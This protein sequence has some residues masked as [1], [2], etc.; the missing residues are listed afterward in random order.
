MKKIIMALAVVAI[1]TVGQAAAFAWST[2]GT[3]HPA[4]DSSA[5]LSFTAYLINS[6]TITQGDLL[7]ALRNGGSITDYSAL[8]TFTGSGKVT[9]TKFNFDIDT[10]K[11]LSAYFVIVDGD[12]VFLSKT[13]TKAAQATSDATLAFASQSAASSSVFGSD[14]A[15]GAAGWYGTAAVPEPTSAMLIVLGV[16][17]LALRRKQK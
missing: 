17:A 16:A 9:S 4:T 14:V 11:N 10:G 7:T 6:S 12:N 3:I 13:V 8:S 1:A 15:Y 5:T 2:T